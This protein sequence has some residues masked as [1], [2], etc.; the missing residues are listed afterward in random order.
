VLRE[1]KKMFRRIS[2]VVNKLKGDVKK[3]I[4]QRAVRRLG[5]ILIERELD[6][7][8]GNLE[9]LKLIILLL[10][11]MIIYAGQV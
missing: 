11:N 10:L 1:C 3:N 4:I 7:L 9:R 8:R 6:I 5:Y 2:I